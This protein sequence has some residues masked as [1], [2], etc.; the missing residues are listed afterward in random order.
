[1]LIEWLI[2]L[3]L[4]AVGWVIG[5]LPDWSFTADA[6]EWGWQLAGMTNYIGGWAPIETMMTCF[7]AWIT[8]EVLY[9]NI[10]VIVWVYNRVR[11]A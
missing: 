3:V 2:D 11:G 1:M 6:T 10:S 8:I 4:T 7:F 9:A 5:L